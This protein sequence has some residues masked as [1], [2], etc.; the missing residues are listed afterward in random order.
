MVPGE[1]AATIRPTETI[2]INHM[3]VE[4]KHWFKATLRIKGASHLHDEIKLILGD[5]TECHKRGDPVPTKPGKHWS[6]D[7]WIINAPIP[8]DAEPSEHLK[9]IEDF[10]HPHEDQ[11][12]QWAGNG[13][14]VDV[15]LSYACSCQHHGFGLPAEVLGMFVRLNI[16]LEVSVVL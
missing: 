6:N 8:E 12:K 2:G 16:P 1:V 3:D 4:N 5:G 9:W 14:K 15:Y 11:I 10:I 13:A 7:I